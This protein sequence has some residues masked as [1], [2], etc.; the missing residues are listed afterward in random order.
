[1]KSTTK[2]ILSENQRALA[3]MLVAGQ[4]WGNKKSLC[5]KCQQEKSRKGGFLRIM[6]GIQKFVC[7]DCMDAKK[8]AV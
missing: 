4:S 7:K 2:S 3:P 1:M 6:P 8:E 5:W